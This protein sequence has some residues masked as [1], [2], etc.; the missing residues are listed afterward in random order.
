VR[1]PSRATGGFGAKACVYSTA[2]TA[3]TVCPAGYPTG[4]V[5]TYLDTSE[6]RSC[7]VC[8]CGG[9]PTGGS[10]TGT[11]SLYGDFPDAG[12]TGAPDTYAIGTCQCYGKSLCGA[13][14]LVILN[15]EPGWVRAQYTVMAGTCATLA[16]PASLGSATPGRPF[17][18]CCM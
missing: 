16:P 14:D 8:T 15:N 12:C 17:T 13:N 7:D 10:C 4:P 9:A 18:V 1:A 3:P 2:T 6:G 11:V 5:N